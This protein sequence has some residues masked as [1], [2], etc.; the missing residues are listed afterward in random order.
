MSIFSSVSPENSFI[1]HLK[2][3]IVYLKQESLQKNKFIESLLV[4]LNK[5]TIND[6][7]KVNHSL[8]DQSGIPSLQPANDCVEMPL[9]NTRKNNDSIANVKNNSGISN[10]KQDAPISKVAIIIGDSQIDL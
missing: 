4:T 5:Y 9:R 3:E 6:T 10:E 7:V 2:T 1:E 8:N